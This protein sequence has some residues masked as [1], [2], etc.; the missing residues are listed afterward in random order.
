MTRWRKNPH[1]NCWLQFVTGI[2]ESRTTHAIWHDS[3]LFLGEPDYLRRHYE[4][5]SDR[6]LALL[7][8]SEAWDDTFRRE[9][10]RE[11]M[12]STWELAFDVDWAR[13]FK[14]WEHRGHDGELDGRPITYDI[15][16]WPQ[17]RTP[18]ERIAL[19][20]DEPPF[21]HFNHTIGTYR[22][23]QRALRGGEPFEDSGFR[24]LLVRLL[25]DL[26]D[27]SDWDYEAP[28]A[29]DLLRGVEDPGATV[30]F[31]SDEARETYPEFRAQLAGLIGSGFLSEER[32]HALARAI[33]PWDAAFGAP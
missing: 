13:S 6:K 31:R 26:L 11:H 19:A 3:D 12:V 25:A 20:A 27:D 4:A 8:L 9:H 14:P 5:I 2:D 30:T 10:G 28:A 21:V 22:N 33:E 7:G 16:F 18:P 23:F 29:A 32:S 17:T 15:T 1:L 24:V